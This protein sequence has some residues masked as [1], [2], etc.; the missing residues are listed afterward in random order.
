MV[1]KNKNTFSLKKPLK[2]K[3][4]IPSFICHKIGKNYPNERN[5]LIKLIDNFISEKKKEHKFESDYAEKNSNIKALNNYKK[6]LNENMTN[7]LYNGKIISSSRQKDLILKYDSIRK[8]IY[9]GGLKYLK[10]Q[11]HQYY[12]QTT[13][14]CLYLS[15]K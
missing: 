6:K 2:D 11:C 9:H 5:Y 8:A 13:W 3:T 7:E 15:D 14:Y 1:K 10:E 12:G 4:T